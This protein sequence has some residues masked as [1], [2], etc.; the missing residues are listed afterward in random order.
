MSVQP[1]GS[2]WAELHAY[3]D[4]AHI[5]AWL[6][7]FCKNDGG[8]SAYHAIW[9][10]AT[11]GIWIVQ[12]AEVVDFIDVHPHI[13][14]RLGDA[15]PVSLADHAGCKALVL[16]AR[17]QTP[18]DDEEAED[19]DDDHFEPLGLVGVEVLVLRL[20]LDWE[21]IATKLPPLVE[22]RLMPG[23]QTRIRRAKTPPKIATY[24]RAGNI[25]FG[26][27]DHESGEELDPPFSLSGSEDDSDETED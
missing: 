24:L 18:D 6:E 25:A 22:P 16:S 17:K 1:G 4:P 19:E 13:S 7:A 2:R 8:N 26:S 9:Y 12:K 3:A 23:Q 20:E 5:R 11:L 15:G 10:G 21:A 27:C 14:A